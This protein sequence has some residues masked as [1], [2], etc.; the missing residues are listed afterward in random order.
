MQLFT[1]SHTENTSK[2]QKNGGFYEYGA[3]TLGAGVSFVCKSL[4]TRSDF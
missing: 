4:R 1:F 2:Q 3:N